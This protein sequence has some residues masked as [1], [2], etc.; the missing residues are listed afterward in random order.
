MDALTQPSVDT[1]L[2]RI[3]S[4][5]SRPISQFNKYEVLELIESLKNA[6]QDA[7]HA[8]QHY[9]RLAYETLRNKIDQSDDQFRD[10]VLPLL[11]D[12]DYEK[13][14]EVVA[15]VE[16]RAARPRTAEFSSQSRRWRSG[17]S[18]NMKCFHCGK[19]GHFQAQCR[20]RKRE[21]EDSMTEDIRSNKNVR[22]QPKQS[23]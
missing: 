19:L 16:K 15:K 12:K 22:P 17:T 18:M 13:I 21:M 23:N 7:N 20:K 4:L 11:G 2:K 5:S 14:L 8:K 6:A 10:L 3:T 9:Y 1:I